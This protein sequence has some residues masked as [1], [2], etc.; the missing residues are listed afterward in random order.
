LGLNDRLNLSIPGEGPPHIKSTKDKDWY[1]TT[2]AWM[3][4]GYELRMTPMQMLTF[5]NAIANN[6]KMVKPKFVKEIRRHG[7]VIRTFPAEIMR[8]SICSPT[9]AAMAKKMMEGVVQ[10]GTASNLKAS[11]YAI[12]GKTGTAQ[13]AQ[14]GDGYKSGKTIYQ[15]SFA[16][17]FPAENPKYTCIVVVSEPSGDAYYGNVVAGP[18]FKEIAD[19]VYSSSLEIH[20]PVNNSEKTFITQLPPVKKSVLNKEN[21][22]M[23]ELNLTPNETNELT[24]QKTMAAIKKNEMPDLIGMGLK[25]VLF[26]ME[27]KGIH[28]KANG[29]GNVT[30]QSIEPGS[31]IERGMEL[32]LDLI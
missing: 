6:G 5:Y 8:E 23:R 27:N 1:G 10:N 4:I 13:I 18:I 20:T 28:V 7:K 12:A 30:K 15:A 22:L 14:G 19:K 24:R 16:G 3:S 25:D 17:Y 26:L 31:K 2:L 9:T 21:V 32:Q 29:R 11:S